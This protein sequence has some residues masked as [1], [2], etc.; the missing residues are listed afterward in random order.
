MSFPAA[1]GRLC[2]ETVPLA[3]WHADCPAQPPSGGCVL[4]QSIVEKFQIDANPAAF[5]RL[6]VETIVK[7]SD[8]DHVR[9]AAFGRLCVETL[10]GAAVYMAQPPAAFGRLCVETSPAA[11]YPYPDG[12]Q[13]PSG[14]CVLKLSVSNT[15]RYAVIQPPS[16]GCVLKPHT[17]LDV[18]TVE[19]QPPSGGCVLKQR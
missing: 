6:C 2:V 10:Y 12:A 11:P 5:G 13:P 3:L 8:R 4:K 1:F 15:R 19:A 7:L 17:V 16:G 14:G 18:Q 9:P